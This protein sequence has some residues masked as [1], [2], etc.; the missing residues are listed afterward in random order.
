MSIFLSS[1]VVLCHSHL[2]SLLNDLLKGHCC[3]RAGCIE[4]L[5]DDVHNLVI[6][7]HSV[8]DVDDVFHDSEFLIVL[9]LVVGLFPFPNTKIQQ[10][11]ESTKFFS[12]FLIFFFSE[13]HTADR[14]R[15]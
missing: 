7:I 4:H 5:A 15:Q 3:L 10:L 2:D 12:L 8:A 11:F 9:L 6:V 14:H 13:F 1:W